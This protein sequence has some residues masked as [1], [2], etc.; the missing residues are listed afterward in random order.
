MLPVC[1]ECHA[2]KH[3]NC[4]G[5]AG[6]DDDDNFIDC[7]CAFFDHDDVVSHSE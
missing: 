5:K 2:G 7:G 1:P 3:W 6:I 4:D